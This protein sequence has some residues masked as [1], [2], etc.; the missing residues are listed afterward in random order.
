[1]MLIAIVGLM[2]AAPIAAQTQQ[3]A[4]EQQ[5]QGAPGSSTGS[6]EVHLAE[7]PPG[8]DESAGGN[9]FDDCHSTA[10][11]NVEIKVTSNAGFDETRTS[12]QVEED[13]PGVGFFG[14]LPAGD[15]T[16]AVNWPVV[17]TDTYW[18]YCS[19]ADSDLEVAVTP[20]DANTGQVTLAE[21]QQLVCD[22]YIVHDPSAL[23]TI[24]LTAFE[25]AANAM[26]PT[27]NPAVTD[28]R[29][30]CPEPATEIDF[31]L[32]DTATD[33]D[34]V[35]TTDEEGAA[36][37]TFDGTTEVELYADVPLEANEWMY[38]AT[39][40]EEPEFVEFD[41]EGVST[42]ESGD[43][44]TMVCSWFLIEDAPT[45]VASA[46]TAPSEPE[47]T[48]APTTEPAAEPALEPSANE[49]GGTQ[50]PADSQ[51][52]AQGP[53]TEPSASVGQI[54]ISP[55]VCPQ[56][57]DATT[58]GL[59]YETFV[60][61]CAEPLA[62][63]GFNLTAAN[64]SVD[65][66]VS[67]GEV[68]ITYADLPPGTFTLHSDIP[69]EAATEYLFCT[70]DGGNRYQKEFD[71]T[72]VT[73]F[74]DLQREQIACEWF[75]VPSSLRGEENGGS[76][77][78]HLAAC[79]VEYTGSRLY[80][81][82]HENGVADQQFTLTGPAGEQTGTTTVPQTPGPGTVTFTNLGAG[83]YTLLGGPPGDF[84]TVKLFCSV[85]PTDEALDVTVDSTIGTLAIGENQ[86][87]LCDW[88]FIPDDA[89]GPVAPTPTATPEPTRAEI[90]VTLYSCPPAANN[91]GTYGGA[92]QQDYVDACT[93]TVNDVPF[94]LGDI[95]APPLRASTGA[96]G[97]GA[98]RFY[99]LL[100]A[101]YTM[102]PLL[103][104]DLSSSAIFCTIG[105]GDS[106]QK[107]LQNGAATFVDVDGEKISCDW[108]AVEARQTQPAGPSGSITVREF[109]CEA[110]RSE[111]TDWE[112]QCAPGASGS[113][114]TLSL[115]GDTSIDDG[116]PDATGVYV[117]TGLT[118]GF[119]EL[120]Q[121]DG[122]WCRAVAD[123]VDSKSRVIVQDGGNTDVVL[124]QCSAVAGLPATGTGPGGTVTA[125]EESGIDRMEIV[126]LALVLLAAP[127]AILGLIQTRKRRRIASAEPIESVLGPIMTASG[128]TW[129]RFK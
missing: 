111:I 13:G 82:C 72:G 49:Q 34:T 79:P 19:E 90:I 2:P 62:D 17:S 16:V 25:C 110:D 71:A 47:P 95:G 77:E 33:A 69:L 35:Q 50:V 65:R 9:F 78:V 54:A 91:S 88:Y 102:A 52:G 48:A 120:K 59:D 3:G 24:E 89:R 22:W 124:Y 98:V 73:T 63:V 37:F 107:A 67:D 44:R 129:M 108:F 46:T 20:N 92:T 80:D 53:T 117:F 57:Y 87:V 10:S 29:A 58:E 30:A 26:T 118:D 74:G 94:T 61:N 100:A 113:S 66:R 6:I 97:D 128:K 109:L 4:P 85:Q 119:F 38:C 42:F 114:F 127:I 116:T 68:A 106:Y 11:E 14:E 103:P 7:C 123:R 21:G 70:A 126:A 105:D 104:D 81:D 76:L 36:T 5:A 28:F 115:S 86:D 93:E 32:I 31:H 41:E 56:D 18:S 60:A 51:G 112:R 55:L 43:Q 96:S 125:A 121:N 15:F 39:N 12:E 83:N 8:F 75:V 45:A 40:E 1:M 122:I 84:G 23:S 99:D 101:D 64:G 27:D